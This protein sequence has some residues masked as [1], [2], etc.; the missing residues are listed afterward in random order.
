MVSI[1]N[2]RAKVYHKTPLSTL[3]IPFEYEEADK[4]PVYVCPP[5]D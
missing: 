4:N 3:H 2:T 5:V 1:N